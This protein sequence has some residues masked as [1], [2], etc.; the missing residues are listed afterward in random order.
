MR[1]QSACFEGDGGVIVLCTM[2][3]VSSSISFSIFHSTWLDT[4][5]AGLRHTCTESL[6]LSSERAQENGTQI[7]MG[8]IV[9]RSR[10]HNA[11]SQPKETGLLGEMAGS[12]AMAGKVYNDLG[13]SC[14]S[15]I[16]KNSSKDI[17]TCHKDICLSEETLTSQLQDNLMIKIN[18]DVNGL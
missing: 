16:Q 8:I 6:I 10:L 17:K 5:A 9:P 2:F 7:P 3:L 14:C 11:H 4:F 13:I 12:R 1:S 18:N 15:R